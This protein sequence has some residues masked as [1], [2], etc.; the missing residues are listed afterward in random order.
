[1]GINQE[2]VAK[3]MDDKSFEDVVKAWVLKKFYVRRNEEHL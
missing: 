3:I 1:M 2:I